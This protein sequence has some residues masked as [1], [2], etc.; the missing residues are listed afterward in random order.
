MV[1]FKLIINDPKTGK[2]YKKPIDGEMSDQFLNKKISEKIQGGQLGFKGY[3]FTITGGSDKQGFPMRPDLDMQSRKK[4][5]A[6][7]GVGIKKKD[8]GIKQR[9]TVRGN[10]ISEQVSQ[11]NLKVTTQGQKSIEECLGLVKEE[12]KPENA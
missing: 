7:T 11:I 9:K 8:P 10:T 12:P 3:E 1:E 2:S 4:I 6:V 5:L